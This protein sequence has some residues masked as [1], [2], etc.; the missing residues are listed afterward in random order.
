ML[1]PIGAGASEN[2]SCVTSTRLGAFVVPV[3]A[4]DISS[5]AI[6]VSRLSDTSSSASVLESSSATVGSPACAGKCSR[7]SIA[8]NFVV[9]D[10]LRRCDERE[11]RRR[12]LLAFALGDDF[13]A[14]LDQPLHPFAGLSLRL[15][16][17][18]PEHL[19]ETLDLAARFFE[20]SFECQL[21]S[22]RIGRLCHLRE[23]LH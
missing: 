23:C 4:S 21:Q 12:G 6:C 10:L 13:L 5:R 2:Y 20:V 22:A 11:I 16:A 15:D 3:R 14:F 9:L 17:H 8:G 19:L 18:Q 1:R 7:R